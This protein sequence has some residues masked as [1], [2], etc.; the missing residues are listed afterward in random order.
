[1][2]E[3]GD[4][5][6]I[7]TSSGGLRGKRNGVLTVFKGI[8]YAQPPT[9]PL[10]FQAPQ[11][12]EPWSGTRDAFEFGP[13]AIQTIR[14]WVNW[15]FTEPQTMDE[16]C[17]TLNVWTPP[18]EEPRP[19]IVWIHGGGYRTGASSM[20]VFDG[21]KFAEIGNVV[22]VSIN[23]RLGVLGW[24][25]HP[26]LRNPDTGTFANWAVQDQIEALRWIKENI[27]AFG[28][29][30][31]RITVMGQ[32]GGAINAIMIA[33]RG[34]TPPLFHQIIAMSAPYIC[35]PACMDMANWSTAME[36]LAEKFG[37]TIPG[38]RGVPAVD[39]H[40]AELQQYEEHLLT[41]DTGR[42]YRG[43]VVD[44]VVLDEWPAFYGLPKMPML[45]GVIGS[46]TASIFNFFDPI[47][48][49]YLTPPPGD[50]ASIR[51]MIQMALSGMYY[52]GDDMPTA[53]D[54]IA[55]YQ[56]SALAD[57]RSEDMATVAVELLG[58]MAGTH[59]ALRKAEGAVLNGHEELY[60]YQY[61]LPLM[62]PN[63]APAHATEL[64]VVFGTFLH[65]YYREKIGDD[66]LQH[67]VSK[68]IIESFS[69]FAATG[70]PS[71]DLLPEWPCFKAPGANVMAFGE[72]DKV[73]EVVDFPKARQLSILDKLASMRQ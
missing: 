3:D 27:A 52:L 31:D 68:A 64:S 55:H 37:T 43:T 72:D 12:I 67:S 32:S 51:E 28:G 63:Q 39:L 61:G 14:A 48:D 47:T 49:T 38:L 36:A 57:G 25:A 19:V 2:S 44:G 22:L 20:P 50:D 5:V 16:D 17:L 71:S 73:G 69:E 70:R 41:T 33:R 62:S 60:F 54:V 4:L 59:Y 53:A 40:N 42:R 1:M 9:G 13:A 8:P 30:P 18:S 35:P 66:D 21:S 65:P 23:Y 11:P 46:E 26:D 34:A 45:I 56:S 15:V 58:D 24:G 10:R 7:Q 6:E 29:D